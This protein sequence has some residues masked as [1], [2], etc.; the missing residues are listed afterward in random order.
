MGGLEP[1]PPFKNFAIHDAKGKSDIFSAEKIEIR[2]NI[3]QSLIERRFSLKRIKLSDSEFSIFRE[4]DGSL[5]LEGSGSMNS[6]SLEQ[7]LRHEIFL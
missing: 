7:L 2:V 1:K 4:I 6:G 5:R 3:F